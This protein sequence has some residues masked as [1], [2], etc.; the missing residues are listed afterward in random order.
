MFKIGTSEVVGFTFPEILA[1]E[2]NKGT[3][4]FV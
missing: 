1:L 2:P 3:F 4:D